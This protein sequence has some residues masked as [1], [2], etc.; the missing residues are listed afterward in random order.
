MPYK[1]KI[2]LCAAFLISTEA[3]IAISSNHM[4]FVRLLAACYNADVDFGD[5]A[6]LV[7]L[8]QIDALGRLSI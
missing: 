5:A 7:Q 8:L 1:Y 4:V 3:K 6:G 2:V